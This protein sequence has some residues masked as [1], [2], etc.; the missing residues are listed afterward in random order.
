MY[1]QNIDKVKKFICPAMSKKIKE[2]CAAALGVY[3]GLCA[4]G[5]G[6]RKLFFYH[7]L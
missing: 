7:L 6:G 2:H 1:F 4:C 3:M 5:H